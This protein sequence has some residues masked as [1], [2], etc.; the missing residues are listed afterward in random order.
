MQADPFRPTS[1]RIS[2]DGT[3]LGGAAPS[4]GFI[5]P[6]TVQR[7]RQKQIQ[8]GSVAISTTQ[9][10]IT[11]DSLIDGSVIE[12]NG[13]SITFDSTSGLGIAGAVASINA[14][15]NKHHVVASNSSGTLV[16]TNE[17]FFE[18][19]GITVAGA[20]D[21]LTSIGFATPTIT[22]PYSNVADF[23]KSQAKSRA[24]AR[25]NKLIKLLSFETTPIGAGAIVATGAGINDAPTSIAF[26]ISYA[27]FANI[28]TYDEF[29]NG[30]LLKG[31]PA[32]KRMV[33]RALLDDT[34][35]VL[36]VLDP[37][38]VATIGTNTFQRGDR[39]I[40]LQIGALTT[41]VNTANSAVTVT[42][43]GET[44]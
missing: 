19:F 21:V 33:V 18:N 17:P 2:I 16:L 5:D 31:V 6:T 38:A 9:N 25:W 39:A 42:V 13:V 41:D 29:N 12:I 37:T 24:N 7:Y 10:G 43:V 22:Y 35:Q 20:E 4:N 1:I 28:F 3:G 11:V 36:P 34:H 32:L 27:N 44:Y 30:A 15:T 8:T 40:N 23:D 14:L 26:T